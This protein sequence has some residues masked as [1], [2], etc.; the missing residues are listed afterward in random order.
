MISTLRTVLFHPDEYF[1]GDDSEVQL[2]DPISILVAYMLLTIMVIV[3]IIFNF[4][5]DTAAKISMVV[6]MSVTSVP[7]I[8][9]KWFLLG[10]ITWGISSVLGGSGPFRRQL[11]LLSFGFL[12]FLISLSFLFLSIVVAVQGIPVGQDPTISQLSFHV[13]LVKS[14]PIVTAALYLY[15][16]TILWG[17]Y[18]WVFVVKH[19]C[20]ISVRRAFIAVLIPVLL[21]IRLQPI[22]L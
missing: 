3:P 18:I 20:N 2:L 16:A 7:V 13:Q 21:L 22:T 5:I 8:L 12:P 14:D 19:T 4:S 10:A 11:V 17:C 9:V 6:G 1:A 15:A